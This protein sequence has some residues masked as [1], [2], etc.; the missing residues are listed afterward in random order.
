[1]PASSYALAEVIANTEIE[2]RSKISKFDR[3][4]IR[5]NGTREVRR[6]E[7]ASAT[8]AEAGLEQASELEAGLAVAPSGIDPK[9]RDPSTKAAF[10]CH[11]LELMCAVG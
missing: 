3:S 5:R 2:E 10:A 1:M 11:S 4:L 8:I 9:G 6:N 7:L